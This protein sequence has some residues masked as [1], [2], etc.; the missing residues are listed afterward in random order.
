MAK[1]WSFREGKLPTKPTPE[2]EKPLS[3]CIEK[4]DLKKSDWKSPLSKTPQ[5]PSERPD[6][7]NVRSFDMVMIEVEETDIANHP[8]WRSG[9]YQVRNLTP[10]NVNEILTVDIN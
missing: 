4:L 9:F 3:W 6:L 1:I 5:F 8:G 2:A 7:D 10:S